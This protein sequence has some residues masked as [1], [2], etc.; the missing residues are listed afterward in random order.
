MRIR[1]KQERERDK[2]RRGFRLERPSQF[3][4]I[5][6]FLIWAM[7][8]RKLRLGKWR[9]IGVLHFRTIEYKWLWDKGV[10]RFRKSRHSWESLAGLLT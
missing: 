4:F 8:N 7:S 2:W 1:E 6:F 9:S 5:K 3:G 10:K